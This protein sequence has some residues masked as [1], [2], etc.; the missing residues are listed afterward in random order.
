MNRQS[1]QIGVILVLVLLIIVVLIGVLIVR[2]GLL[3]RPKATPT[4]TEWWG[5]AIPSATATHTAEPD[6]I[7]TII[8]TAWLTVSAEPTDIPKVTHRATAVISP[9]LTATPI[10]W[11]V[12][13]PVVP[14]PWLA[15]IRSCDPRYTWEACYWR[16]CLQVPAT[17]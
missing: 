3:P 13:P 4:P 2:G 15:I 9:T 17:R 11:T 14:T 7:G 8:P 12:V 1:G 5:T 6:I 10:V 16:C